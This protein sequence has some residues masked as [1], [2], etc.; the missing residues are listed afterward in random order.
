MHCNRSYKHWKTLTYLI[1]EG[2]LNALKKSKKPKTG[3]PFG[4]RN[5]YIRAPPRRP[6]NI[7]IKVYKRGHLPPSR[8]PDNGNTGPVK[9]GRPTNASKLLLA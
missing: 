3:R 8:F 9:K 4:S 2:R 7:D 1:R 6:E 5:S